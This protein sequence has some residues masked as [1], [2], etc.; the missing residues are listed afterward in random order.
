MQT[1]GIR[2]TELTPAELFEDIHRRMGLRNRIS[3][4]RMAIALFEARSPSNNLG[5]YISDGLSLS[6]ECVS[7][8]EAIAQ[9]YST[10]QYRDYT[11]K[12]LWDILTDRL[13]QEPDRNKLQTYRKGFSTAHDVFGAIQ[14]KREPDPQMVRL[15]KQVMGEIDKE[16]ESI[17][18]S[19]E[20]LCRGSF[21][22]R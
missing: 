1:Y 2:E 17:Y 21:I 8:L 12:V 22:P 16:I 14:A 11:S 7:T 13:S 3:N 6:K 9:S 4:A 15:A 19:E 10:Y 20:T 18:A 5:K